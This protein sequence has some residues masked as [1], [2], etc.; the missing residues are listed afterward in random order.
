MNMDFLDLIFLLLTNLIIKFSENIVSYSHFKFN[1]LI[2][3]NL[4]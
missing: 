1:N 3:Y 2:K 4:Y